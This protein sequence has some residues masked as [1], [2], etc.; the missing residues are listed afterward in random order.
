MKDY[1]GTYRTNNVLKKLYTVLV[2]LLPATSVYASPVPSV[3]LGEI[4]LFVLCMIL[5]GDMEKKRNIVIKKSYFLTYIAYALVITF[6]S[7]LIF[8][9]ILPSFSHMDPM[10]RIIRDMVYF[11]LVLFFA[12]IYFDFEYGI[13]SIRKV[14]FVLGI[15]VF[16][17]FIVYDLINVF[18]PGIIPQAKTTISGGF[19]GAQLTK[20]FAMSAAIDGFARPNGFFAEPAV[21]AQYVSVGLLLEIFPLKGKVNMK[22]AI[23]YSAI[24][25]ITFSVNA[26]VALFACWAL[27]TIYN[28]KG[29]RDRII[30]III[31]ISFMI[32]SL[33]IMMQNAKTASVIK[34]LIELMRG[35]RTSGSSVIRV[36]RGIAFFFNMPILYQIFG[37]GFGNFLQFKSIYNISTV[38]ETADEYM[39][40]NAY[41]LVSAGIIGFLL[42]VIALYKESKK[43]NILAGMIAII[44][45]VFG[46]SSSIYSS[47]VYVV[48][49]AFFITTPEKGRVVNES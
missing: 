13:K 17:Q 12:P 2:L 31:A 34:R 4:I 10:K 49:L 24:M 41:I 35:K 38:Y 27:W 44:I 19:T 29:N 3:S 28:N 8:A 43:R 26:Y 15:F 21:I 36:V 9:F 37:S 39:N 1:A 46:L 6:A 25:L 18:V 23:F 32:I 16:M 33:L 42:Y 5:L 22:R 7:C 48:M 40:T 20:K 14:I 47:A 11:S 45:F 30:R